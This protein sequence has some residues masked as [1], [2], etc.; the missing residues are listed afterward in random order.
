[1]KRKENI[2]IIVVYIYMCVCLCVRV[3]VCLFVCACVSV[4]GLI[5]C[6]ITLEQGITNREFTI[7]TIH[8][9]AGNIIFV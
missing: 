9:V 7:L 1:M 4:C 3:C 5:P 6:E 8:R 2:Q